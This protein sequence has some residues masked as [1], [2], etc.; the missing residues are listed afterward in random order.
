MIR[1]ECSKCSHKKPLYFKDR[2]GLKS[3]NYTNGL[4]KSCLDV[5]SNDFEEW[6]NYFHND[7]I[8]DQT[9]YY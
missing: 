4:C 6:M 2:D 7:D 9:N 5:L 3:V 1:L 8:I